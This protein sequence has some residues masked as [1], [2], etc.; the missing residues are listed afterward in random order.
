MAAKVPISVPDFQQAL[1]AIYQKAISGMPQIEKPIPVLADEYLSRYGSIPKAADKLISAQLAKCATSSF[2]AG[3]GGV[4]TLPVT[5]PADI[6]S[7]L[8]FQIRMIASVAYIGGY[9]ICEDQVQTFIYVCLA[10]ISVNSVVKSFGTK[11]GTKIATKAIE[12]IPGKALTKINQKVAFRLIT[13]FG[14]KGLINLG[15][16]IP[17]V[18]GVIGGGFTL[19]E[20]KIIAA[21]A[22]KMFIVDDFALPEPLRK[23]ESEAL[24]EDYIETEFLHDDFLE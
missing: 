12:R 20:T 7:V 11:F 2:L 22:R 13:K 10:G 24:R 15:K 8:Y 19:T 17:L 18:G 5:L 23:E 21:R 9:D 16:M 1:D 6:C 3:L 4:V 14:E